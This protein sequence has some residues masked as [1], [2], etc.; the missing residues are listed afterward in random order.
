MCRD[1]QEDRRAHES[2]VTNLF[3]E[4]SHQV[5]ADKTLQATRCWLSALEWACLVITA[6]AHQSGP[7]NHSF[8][9]R[10]SATRSASQQI[11]PASDRS[12]APEVDG[13]TRKA[14]AQCRQAGSSLKAKQRVTGDW[15]W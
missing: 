2:I 5:I 7:R 11:P 12:Q 9:W 1:D 4:G 3:T 14:F 10:A 13:T 8:A 15:D 6:V